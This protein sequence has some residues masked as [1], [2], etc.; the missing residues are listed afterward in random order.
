M[1]QTFY[2]NLELFLLV[3][4]FRYI[5]LKQ[6]K[7]LLQLRKIIGAIFGYRI[8]KVIFNYAHRTNQIFQI[9]L[10]VNLLKRVFYGFYIILQCVYLDFL[11]QN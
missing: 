8:T 11:I 10:V 2:Q 9:S 4:S 1:Q 3:L 5:Y 6:R 7:I